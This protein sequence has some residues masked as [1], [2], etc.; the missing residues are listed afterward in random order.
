[1]AQPTLAAH[2]EIGG[3]GTFR[4]VGGLEAEPPRPR[5]RVP[6]FFTVLLG[7]LGISTALGLA[8]ISPVRAST[9]AVLAFD[10]PTCPTPQAASGLPSAGRASSAGPN[11]LPSAGSGGNA[12]ADDGNTFTLGGI[13]DRSGNRGDD[14]TE[15]PAQPVPSV[16]LRPQPSATRLANA[17]PKVSALE[18]ARPNPTPSPTGTVRAG[19][20]LPRINAEPGQPVV[21]ATPSNLTGSKVTMIGLRFEGIV[22][23][24]TVDGT[25][26]AV[27]FSMER[28]VIHDFLLRAPGPAGITMRFASDRLTVSGNVNFYATRFVGWLFGIKIMLAPDLPLPDGMQITTPIPITFSDPAIDLAF[29]DSDTVTAWPALRGTLD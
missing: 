29:V 26:K 14:E 1:M 12:E 16:T 18:C 8:G 20:P 2:E 22:D 19:K 25:L 23:L 15:A 5:Q 24:P 7:L 10:G 21:A 27:K 3:P 9:F 13:G 6:R 28:A 11:G 4:R 17:T